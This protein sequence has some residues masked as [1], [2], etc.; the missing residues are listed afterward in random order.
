[1]GRRVGGAVARNRIKRQLREAFWSVAADLE[2]DHDFVIVA[3]AEVGG[4]EQAEGLDGLERSL[5]ELIAKLGW[6]QGAA[7]DERP[8]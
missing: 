1:V 5:R 6:D 3:R 7:G 8:S 2:D 4:L